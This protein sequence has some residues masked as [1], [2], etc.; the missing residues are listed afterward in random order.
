MTMEKGRKQELLDIQSAKTCECA[1]KT[2]QS[3]FLNSEY[4]GGSN[5]N[6][7]R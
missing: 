5:V 7:I 4:R 6:S 2:L 3:P 1:R